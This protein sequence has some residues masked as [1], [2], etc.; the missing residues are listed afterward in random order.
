MCFWQQHFL[1]YYYKWRSK[2]V[3]GLKSATADEFC[4]WCACSAAHKHEYLA[5]YPVVSYL[6]DLVH[7]LAAAAAADAVDV[8]AFAGR[9]RGIQRLT[10]QR[11]DYL[12]A[13]AL[14]DKQLA[15]AA[16]ESV[17]NPNVPGLSDSPFATALAKAQHK[18]AT[19]RLAA[20]ATAKTTNAELPQPQ[21]RPRNRNRNRSRTRDDEPAT[22][23][24]TITN[25]SSQNK[26]QPQQ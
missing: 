4:P 10:L 21:Q 12:R 13:Y 18:R 26:V 22:T 9:A 25:N 19:A 20:S 17:V 8:D 14:G 23:T 24:T 16:Y 3:A 5:W 6:H 7:D 2:L 11:L 15:T 1:N